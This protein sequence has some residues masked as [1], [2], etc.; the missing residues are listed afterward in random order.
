MIIASTETV[1]RRLTI[2]ADCPHIRV[3]LGV[4]Q[5]AKCGCILQAKARI[6]GAKCP[7]NKWSEENVNAE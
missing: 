2:C 3:K 7:I 1:T 6:D 5:C 4:G